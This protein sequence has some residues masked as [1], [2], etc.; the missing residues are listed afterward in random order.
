MNSKILFKDELIH[1]II[2]IIGMMVVTSGGYAVLD[3]ITGDN[4]NVYR[5]IFGVLISL[6]IYSLI[7]TSKQVRIQ[8]HNLIK[9]IY[10]DY[11][12][13]VYREKSLSLSI[14]TEIEMTQKE[15]KYFH[16]IAKASNDDLLI[17][18]EPNKF[19]AQKRL[20]IVRSY[21]DL[22]SELI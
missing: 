2:Q 13:F 6:I 12:G 20:D 18:K 15:D 7:K 22:K 1:P 5:I 21:F 19:P 10:L 17:V 9:G 16:I 3:R 11:I 4:I 14:I 8:E